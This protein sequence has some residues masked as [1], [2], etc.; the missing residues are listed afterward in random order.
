MT[1]TKQAVEI[2]PFSVDDVVSGRADAIVEL[3][4]GQFVSGRLDT[5]YQ[6]VPIG[7]AEEVVT[8]GRPPGLTT[9]ENDEQIWA[10]I[11]EM[12][13]QGRR[14]TQRSLAAFSSSFTVDELQGYLKVTNRSWKEFLGN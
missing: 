7:P 12:K 4:D 2:A 11:R 8:R 5:T 6:V 13:K 1:R 9:I 14:I 3:P 10:P